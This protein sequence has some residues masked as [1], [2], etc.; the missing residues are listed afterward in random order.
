MMEHGVSYDLV[1]DPAVLRVF[2]CPE[3]HKIQ[4]GIPKFYL[5]CLKVLRLIR[6]R[7]HSYWVPDNFILVGLEELNQ[8]ICE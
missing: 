4:F 5:G 3:V 7:F 1:R 6:I 8:A 2:F